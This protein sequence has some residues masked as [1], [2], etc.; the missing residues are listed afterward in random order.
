MGIV[1]TIIVGP[2][3]PAAIGAVGSGSTMFLAVM[4]LGMGTLLALDTFV[5]Q[6]YGAGRIDECHR[7][8]FAGLQLAGVMS[9]ILVI[10]GA[11]GVVAAVVRGYAPGRD[12]PAAALPLG[13][14]LVGAAAAGVHGLPA[15]SAGDGRGEANHG[16]ARQR[17]PDQRRRQ[18]DPRLRPSRL[19]RAWRAG[20]RVR[21]GRGA[22]L[23][24]VVPLRRGGDARAAPAVG[25]TRRPVRDRSGADVGAAPARR[26]GRD[27]GHAR[28]RRLCR[29]IRA[30][31]AHHAARRR[32]QSNRPQHCR[33]LLHD[34][35][36]P[37][38][39]RSRSRRPRGRTARS[40][41]RP[42]SLE[43]SRSAWPRP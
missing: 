5:A 9:V 35:V 26:A 8:L 18:L 32:R 24:G 3:G 2:L 6:N 40:A 31:G 37:E 14:S 41:W 39:G 4:V 15:I 30:G 34:S 16:R 29:G 33:V 42:R 7:W 12:R 10:A 13:S 22:R 1:D 23:P 36:R 19:S 28:G 43:P 11:A 27:A 21:D 20:V 38:L 17:Q 25:T